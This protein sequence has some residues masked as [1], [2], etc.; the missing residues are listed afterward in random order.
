MLKDTK[1]ANQAHPL[2]NIRSCHS[3]DKGVN[4]G[5]WGGEERAAVTGQLGSMGNSQLEMRVRC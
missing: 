3:L 1:Q 4:W 5:G 2:P